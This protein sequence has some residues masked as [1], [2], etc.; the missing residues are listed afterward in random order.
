ML[1]YWS[2]FCRFSDQLF[3]SSHGMKILKLGSWS[4][5]QVIQDWLFWHRG[6]NKSFSLFSFSS[7]HL[8]FS[9]LLLFSFFSIFVFLLLFLVN[10]VS[11]FSE[12]VKIESALWKLKVNYEIWSSWLIVFLLFSFLFLSLIQA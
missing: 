1:V 6:S 5:H 9:F 8:Y 7:F 12:K 2:A 4:F 10:M 11:S 3:F